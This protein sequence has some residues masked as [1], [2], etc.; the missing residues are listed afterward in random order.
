MTSTLL[1]ADVRYSSDEVAADVRDR[2][3]DSLTLFGELDDPQRRQLALD[4]WTIG[5]R[6]LYNAH[7]AAQESKLK[8]IGESL[9]GDIG[10]QLSAHIERQQETIA[11]V[12]GRFFDPTDG[13]VNQRLTAF[14]NDDGVLARVLD[15]Y[16]G[17]GNSVLPETL[18]RQVGQSSPLLK[19]LSPT[20]SE[21]VIKTLET[22]LRTVM[23]NGHA[24]VLKTLDPLT[25]DGAVARFLKSLREELKAANQDRAAQLSAA[26][27]ALDANDENSLLSR[28]VRETNQARQDVLTAVNPETPSSPM[29]VLKSSLTSLLQQQFASQ[30]EVANKQ[31]ERQTRFE[32]EVREA[33]TRIETKRAQDQTSPRGGLDFEDEVTRFV[34]TATQGGPCVFTAVGATAGIG[35]CKKGDAVLRFTAESVFA[36]A[37]V[38]F[39]AKR[40]AG[41]TVQAAL[42]ELDEARKNRDAGAGVFVMARSHASEVFPRF[43]RYGSNVLVTWDE[44]DPR[45]DPYLHAAILLG[46]S[47]VTRSRTTGDVGDITALKDIEARIEGELSRLE[48]MEKYT[49]NIRKNVDDIGDEV[50]KAQ[51][52]LDILLRKAQRTLLALKVELHDEEGERDSPITLPNGSFDEA[53]MALSNS[54]EAA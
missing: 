38:V 10:R 2:R 50:R 19:K 7:T 17:P 46:M 32:N 41:Y 48:K 52:A 16:L 43:V 21:G 35:R 15:K 13:H 39:E 44:Q 30:A 53:V 40:E 5:L 22:Q 20:D 42:A 31:Q 36:N 54:G 23:E 33:L 45:T 28:L 11:E 49:H 25:D 6:A 8:D 9:M 37:G 1:S 47:L 4:A 27:A 18:A 29:A 14:L 34:N 12:L 24:E 26:L 51:K 3:P